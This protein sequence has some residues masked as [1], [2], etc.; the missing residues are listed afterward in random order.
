MARD[1]LFKLVS[2]VSLGVTL[3]FSLSSMVRA[4]SSEID[5]REALAPQ[6]DQAGADPQRHAS[7]PPPGAPSEDGR[8]NVW[9]TSG[10]VEVSPHIPSNTF[11]NAVPNGAYGVPSGVIVDGR[12][13]MPDIHVPRPLPN[14][15]I[16]R[17][18]E[19]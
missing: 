3:L 17:G 19:R 15:G 7:R 18:S 9:D 11:E 13:S 2:K 1:R 6:Q 12:P 16:D 10:P 5:A 8:M 14:H 4:D